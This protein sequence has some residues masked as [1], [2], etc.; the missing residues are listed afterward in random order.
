MSLVAT[1]AVVGVAL[2]AAGSRFVAHLLYGAASA[3][4]LYFL[5]GAAVI[6]LV[7]LA[8]TVVP[9]RRAAAVEPL[10]ALRHE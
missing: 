10:V 3:D 7:G 8:A 9:A 5:A 4:W 2:A 6:S 1:G